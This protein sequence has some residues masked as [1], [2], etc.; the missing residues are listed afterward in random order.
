MILLRK[1]LNFTKKKMKKMTRNNNLDVITIDGPVGVG[2][3]TVA[4]I[5]SERLGY[6]YLDTGAMYRAFSLKVLNEGISIEDVELIIGLSKRTKIWFDNNKVFLD[7]KDVSEL[8]RTKEIEAIVSQISAIPEV[9]KFI[10]S[11]QREIISKGRVIMEGRDCGTVIAPNAKYKFYL[12]ASIEERAKRRFL[13]KK[14]SN[15]D[16]SIEKVRKSIEERD[17][18]DKTRKDSP[19]RVPEDAIIINTDGMTVDEVVEKIISYINNLQNLP[20]KESI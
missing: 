14:Y 2:K 1:L 13:D 17:Y 3:S 19:L 6:V 18:I 12:D 7:G 10:V 16:S 11:I 15:K 20:V 4:K 5:I 9:R 8:I